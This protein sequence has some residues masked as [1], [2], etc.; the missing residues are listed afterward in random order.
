MLLAMTES[1]N[2]RH[3]NLARW[4]SLT[5][6]LRALAVH[7]VVESPLNIHDLATSVYILVGCE[8]SNIALELNQSLRV[9]LALSLR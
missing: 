3:E 7:V 1:F 5:A 9:V 4:K 2:G 6:L 8:E